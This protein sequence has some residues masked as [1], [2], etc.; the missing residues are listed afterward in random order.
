[1]ILDDL[2]HLKAYSALHP[3]IEQAAAFLK[4]CQEDNLAAGTY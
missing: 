3:A 4:K 2:N 1:M